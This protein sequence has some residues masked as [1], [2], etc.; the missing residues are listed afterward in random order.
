MD[1][2]LLPI[3]KTMEIKSKIKKVFF[4]FF[5]L[6][7]FQR[8]SISAYSLAPE[9]NYKP[10]YKFSKN[11]SNDNKE[12]FVKEVFDGD[13]ISII[14][15]NHNKNTRYEKI[16]LLG[17][18]AFEKDQNEFGMLGKQYL[19][20]LLLSK[21][22]CIET[23]VQEKDKYE[24]TLGYVFLGRAL[25]KKRFINE[26]LVKNGYALLYS[27][28]PNIKYIEGLKK[29]QV[30]ARANMLGVW[31]KNEYILETPSEYRKKHKNDSKFKKRLKKS[32]KLTKKL[33]SF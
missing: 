2:A 16:R 30:Y 27:Y 21:K 28:P 26:D 17:I 20:M 25:D 1:M 10:E 23:D 33:N 7:I 13:T 3:K 5:L 22:V 6:S 29:A 4:I 24:R 11:C 14:P 15:I 18:D 12:Y 19:T 8:C 9:S 31:S 32:K